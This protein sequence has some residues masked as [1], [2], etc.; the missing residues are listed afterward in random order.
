[1]IR[2]KCMSQITKDAGLSRE[3]RWHAV[4][5]GGNPNRASELKIVQTLGVRLPAQ[6][7]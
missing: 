7:A 4:I 3:S 1:M 5:E 2:A 6:P